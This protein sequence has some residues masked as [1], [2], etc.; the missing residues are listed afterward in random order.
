MSS[1]RRSRVQ[2]YAAQSD[3]GLAGVV[4]GS[5]SVAGGPGYDVARTGFQR[6]YAHRP[7]VVVG[8][9]GA[10][11]VRAAV[12]HAAAHGLAVSIQA[13]G[14]GLSVPSEGGVLIDT[15]RF[16]GVEVN[17][18][19][20]RARIEAGA[21]WK[22]VIEIT[23]AHGLAPL[24]G[25]SPTV[26]AVGYTLGGGLGLLSRAHGWAADRVEAVEVVL[27]DG[28]LRRVTA[29]AEPDLFWAVRGGRD[30]F[31][32]VTAIEIELFAVPKVFGGALVFEGDRALEVLHAYRRWTDTVPEEMSSSA[33]ILSFP[34]LPS[35]P[36]PQRGERIVQLQITYAGDPTE[37]AR[38]VAPLRKIGGLREDTLHDMSFADSHVIHSDPTDPH[39][40]QGEGVLVRGLDDDVLGRVFELCGPQAAAMSVLTVKHLGGAL[41]RPA[42][43]PN[44]VGHREAAFLVTLINPVTSAPVSTDGEVRADAASGVSASTMGTGFHAVDSD[45]ADIRLL[46]GEFATVLRPVTLGRSMNFLFGERTAAARTSTHCP[47]VARRLDELRAHYDPTGMFVR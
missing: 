10:A 15:A 1:L 22:D 30:G 29:D 9:V 4:R 18:G 45:I 14:H 11:D 8:A 47:A 7:S 23:A 17:V 32:V 5:V 27:A 13:T 3:Q 25:S 41:A 39:A 19:R 6:G 40:Y 24:S 2:E 34:R 28:R 20:R 12:D 16:D 33:T 35:I 44:A 43:V 46:H 36:E 42:E 37:G 21:R 38:L 31:G 26:G